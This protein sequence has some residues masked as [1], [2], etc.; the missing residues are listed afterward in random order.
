MTGDIIAKIKSGYNQ[1]TNAEKQVASYITSN[2]QDVLFMSITDL[3]DACGVG[4]TTVFRF[5]K[6]LGLK[7]YQEFKMKLSLSISDG[8]EEMDQYTGNNIEADDSVLDIAKKVLATNIKALEE[9]YSLINEENIDKAIEMF[10]EAKKVYF[11]GVGSSMLTAMKATN[12]FLRI[13]NKVYCVE[14]SH[15]QA[16]MAAT[17]TQ[18]DLAIFISYSGATKDTIHVAKL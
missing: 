5:C 4:D 15:M 17:M 14:D 10:Y 7:G 1:F 9:T 6:S 16:M 8:K 18:D 11:F 13:E 2:V 3:A 12:K